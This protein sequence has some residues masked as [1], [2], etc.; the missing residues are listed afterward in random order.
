LWKRFPPSFPLR[1]TVGGQKLT[2]PK[3][4]FLFTRL[5]FGF[6]KIFSKADE[7]LLD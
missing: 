5:L 3:P 1:G 4:P 2:S 6:T 7:E